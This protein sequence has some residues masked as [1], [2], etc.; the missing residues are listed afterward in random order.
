M[1]HVPNGAVGETGP[2][3]ENISSNETRTANNCYLPCTARAARGFPNL[4]LEK[5]DD[6]SH[7]SMP[8]WQ[9]GI[10]KAGFGDLDAALSGIPLE[11]IPL[12]L[13]CGFPWISNIHSSH[14]NGRDDNVCWDSKMTRRSFTPR[15]FLPLA[16]C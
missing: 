14:E 5:E 13:Q 6:L 16:S 3:N 9:V 2:G 4:R 8:T 10:V 12:V 7:P 11:S 15:N 1:G